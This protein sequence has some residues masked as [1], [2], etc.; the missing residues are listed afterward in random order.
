MPEPLVLIQYR[1]RSLS[2]DDMASQYNKVYALTRP[3]FCDDASLRLFNIK[4]TDILLLRGWREYF[5]GSPFEARRHW[6]KAFYQIL[7][8]PALFMAY[9]ITFLPGPLFVSFKENRFRFRL[10]YFRILRRED[11]TRYKKLLRHF[12]N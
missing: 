5:F 8:Q 4:E 9:L 6:R 7:S 2:R 1:K 11:R 3:L 12:L 10:D